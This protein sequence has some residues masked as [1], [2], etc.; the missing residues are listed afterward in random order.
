MKPMMID[1]PLSTQM[2]TLILQTPWFSQ[3][4]TN[5]DDSRACAQACLLMLLHF[6][7]SIPQNSALSLEDLCAMKPDC[8]AARDLVSL[9]AKPSFNLSLMPFVLGNIL[10]LRQYLLAGHPVMV[11]VNYA[12]LDFEI[13]LALDE[14]LRNHWLLVVGYDCDEFVL[15]DPLWLPNQR[16]GH[17][18]AYRKVYYTTLQAALARHQQPN[19]IY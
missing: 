11:L 7:R 1:L 2:T 14:D 9:A 4:K 3:L 19:A 5:G 13:H 10:S 16:R 18:G 17:G 12:L 15:H 6:Y 8:M